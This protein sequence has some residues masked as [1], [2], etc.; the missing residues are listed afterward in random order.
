MSG[1]PLPHRTLFVGRHSE[2]AVLRANLDTTLQG[3]GGVVLVAGEAGIGKSSL[4]Q[5]LAA[6]AAVR[7]ALVLTGHCGEDDALALPYL[8]FVEALRAVVRSHE[9]AALAHVLGTDAAEVGVF[10]DR[11][12]GR[13][14]VVCALDNLGKGAAGQAVQNVNVLFG[15]AES[16]GL[17]LSGV[18]V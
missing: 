2:L 9:P 12:T 10:D 15:F 5:C 14:I 3:A 16:A 6:E 18:R 8:P 7:G 4:C 17:R 13:T 1:L 11:F